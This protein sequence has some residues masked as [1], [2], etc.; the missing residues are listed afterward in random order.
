MRRLARRGGQVQAQRRVFELRERRLVTPFIRTGE[1]EVEVRTEQCGPLSFSERMIEP[2]VARV[3][4]VDAR[5]GVQR[6]SAKRGRRTLLE[7][8]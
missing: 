6:Q 8:A 5:H 7:G 4:R 1:L 2:F 3:A